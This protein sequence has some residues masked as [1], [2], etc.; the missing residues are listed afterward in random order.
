MQSNSNGE[1]FWDSQ[2]QGLILGGF[3]YGYVTTQILGGYLSEN[4]GGKWIFGV[5]I[6]VSTAIG[7][8]SPT[9]AK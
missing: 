9:L 6:F 1:F 2:L 5:G 4:Y 8:L 3:S 7:L